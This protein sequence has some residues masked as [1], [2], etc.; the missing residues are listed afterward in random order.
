MC[1]LGYKSESSQGAHSRDWIP[2]VAIAGPLVRQR[3]QKKKRQTAEENPFSAHLYLLVRRETALH[4]RGSK[5]MS[6]STGRFASYRNS[7]ETIL[8]QQY[9]FAACA[10]CLA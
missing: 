4:F 2:V 9:R 8:L 6:S 1:V 7:L 5:K 10:E 3:W